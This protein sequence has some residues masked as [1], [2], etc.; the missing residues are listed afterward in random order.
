MH[1]R[2]IVPVISKEFAAMVFEKCSAAAREDVELSM[3]LLD[4]GPASIE[5]EY[6][7]ALATPGTIEKIVQAEKEGVDAVVLP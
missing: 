6:D 4:Y 7:K 5:S 3:A 1:I 2:V